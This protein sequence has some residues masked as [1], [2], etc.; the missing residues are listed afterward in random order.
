[1]KQPMPKMTSA[2][3]YSCSPALFDRLWRSIQA[4]EVDDLVEAW[5][6]HES[7]DPPKTRWDSDGFVQLPTL[8]RWSVSSNH[9]TF[10]LQINERKLPAKVRDELVRSKATALEDAQ[11]RRVSKKEYRLLV[12]E[13]EM[14]LLPKAFI[15]RTQVLVSITDT[16]RVVV[17]TSS[18]KRADRV[19]NSLGMMLTAVQ[20]LSIEYEFAPIAS[21]QLPA[22]TFTRLVKS[23][24]GTEDKLAAGFA[25]VLKAS[26]GSSENPTIRVRNRDLDAADI[27][28]LLASGEDYKVVE[29]ELLYDEDGNFSTI[30]RAVGCV[31]TVNEGLIIKK[32]AVP[33]VTL[34]RGADAIAAFDST[35]F[36]TLSMLLKVH[37]AVMAE[38]GVM[39]GDV[40]YEDEDE[41]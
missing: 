31:F 35:L 41:I 1:M 27:Q 11:G 24:P 18:V 33:G 17:W 22:I 34:E 12:E 36:L 28:K 32:I 4:D 19:M 30:D 38:T 3:V 15:G 9:I 26:D 5:E 37:A 16:A 10:C 29:V 21:M 23:A 2:I 7:V 40:E 20:S 13:A 25:C 6:E 8:D 39:G 14:E